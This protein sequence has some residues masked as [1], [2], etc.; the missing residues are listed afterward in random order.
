MVI[1]ILCGSISIILLSPSMF[2]GR[3]NNTLLC[4]HQR[5]ILGIQKGN[6]H[7]RACL[8]WFS[9]MVVRRTKAGGL[10][11]S[12]DPSLGNFRDFGKGL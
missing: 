5:V 12:G 11:L 4:L 8:A 1:R 6:G 2:A 3:L 7:Q 10:V 9:R